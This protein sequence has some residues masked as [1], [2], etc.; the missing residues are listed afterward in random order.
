VTVNELV[1]ASVCWSYC[2]GS[3]SN[4]GEL[5]DGSVG[6]ATVPVS[7]HDK[8]QPNPGATT[9]TLDVLHGESQISGTPP[10]RNPP[11]AIRPW[12]NSA[13]KENPLANRTALAA[14]TW[15]PV[16]VPPRC[17]ART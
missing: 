14:T 3:C 10:S 8:S 9:P 2:G 12:G 13:A 11:P 7:V 6:L 17:S 15:N 1:V 5:P 16:L 4:A